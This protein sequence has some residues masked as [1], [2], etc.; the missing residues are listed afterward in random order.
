MY[1][2]LSDGSLHYRI[3]TIAIS[4]HAAAMGAGGRRGPHEGMEKLLVTLE[5]CDVLSPEDG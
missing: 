3:V 5:R 1:W 4:A 2:L